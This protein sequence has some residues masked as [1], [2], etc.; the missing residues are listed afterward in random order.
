M[1]LD[2]GSEIP[3]DLPEKISQLTEFAISDEKILKII[4]NLNSNK[5]H[6]WD[7]ISVKMI[8]ICDESLIVPLRL[9]FEN[10]LRKGI[11]PEPWKRANV[12]PVHK[13]NEK[14]VKGNH[15]PISLPPIFAKIPEKLVYDSL[16]SHLFFSKFNIKIYNL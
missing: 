13:K 9:I 8:K 10:C 4:R 1:T 15:R 2:T 6:G 12:V 16:Y 7:G 5:A 3:C 11:F 14:N